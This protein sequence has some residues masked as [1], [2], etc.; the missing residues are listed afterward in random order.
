MDIQL[1]SLNVKF[2]VINAC[3]ISKSFKEIIFTI[4]GTSSSSLSNLLNDNDYNMSIDAKQ[5]EYIALLMPHIGSYWNANKYYEYKQVNVGIDSYNQSSSNNNDI[6]IFSAS[7]I[8]KC[9]EIFEILQD[10]LHND[11]SIENHSDKRTEFSN[12]QMVSPI[13][14][15]LYASIAEFVSLSSS[16]AYELMDTIMHNFYFL[17]L[18]M[19]SVLKV[20]F[21]TLGTIIIIITIAFI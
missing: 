13:L 1:N 21:I 2:N 3:N 7:I 6:T 4:L 17:I 14:C 18:E 8:G 15:S 9:L 16:T 19:V 12:W 11:Y 20:N 5:N 10:R